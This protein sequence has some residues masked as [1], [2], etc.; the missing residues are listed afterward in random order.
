M[1]TAASETAEWM[2]SIAGA[3]IAA[4]LIFLTALAAIRYARLRDDRRSAGDQRR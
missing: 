2:L 3:G 4:L 1:L